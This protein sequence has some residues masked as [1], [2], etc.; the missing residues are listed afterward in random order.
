MRSAQQLLRVMMTNPLPTPSL[1]QYINASH[2]FA[3]AL[4]EQEI[5]GLLQGSKFLN[6][7]G[8]LLGLGTLHL[9]PSGSPVVSKF[10]EYL[11]RIT[12]DTDVANILRVKTHVSE[13]TAV[14]HIENSTNVRM[15]ALK[16]R[17]LFVV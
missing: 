17:A 8:N 3:N 5:P 2:F 13:E 16:A 4:S 9:S 7:W 15:W 10:Q 6:T 12:N 1:V 14:E 11:Q